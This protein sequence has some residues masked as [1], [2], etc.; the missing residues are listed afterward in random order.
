MRRMIEVLRKSRV[1]K[2]LLIGV[3]LAVSAA[4]VN[5][6]SAPP[7]W[8]VFLPGSTAKSSEV[9]ENFKILLDRAWDLSTNGL[10]LYYKG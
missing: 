1:H 7:T 10:D 2:Y 8:T 6:A 4:V 3:V 5:A 9:N